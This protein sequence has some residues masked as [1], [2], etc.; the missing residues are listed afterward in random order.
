MLENGISATT[1]PHE[2]KFQGLT[3]FMKRY[4]T[5]KVEAETIN[6]YAGQLDDAMKQFMVCQT[7]IQFLHACLTT[8]KSSMAVYMGF[9]LHSVGQDLQRL[10]LSSSVANKGQ[11]PRS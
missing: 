4:G 5:V 2:P 8:K 1:V 9:K 10:V 7:V 3:T 11:L 6:G